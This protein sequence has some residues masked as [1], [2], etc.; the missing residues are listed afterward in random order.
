ME[1]EIGI[2]KECPKTQSAH[3][4][5]GG[6][7]KPTGTVGKSGSGR[8]DGFSNIK[9][10]RPTCEHKHTKDEA[11][12]GTVLDPFV[13]SGT[14]V[15]VA[16]Q[17]IRR[18]I[19]LDISMEYIDQQAKIRTGEGSPSGVLDDLPLFDKTHEGV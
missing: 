1:K 6:E 17:L 13:G 12:P 18:G 15:M 2:S 7:G 4:A 11:I 9:E 19:G 3:E 16:K 10:Y 14:T 8:I 5:R